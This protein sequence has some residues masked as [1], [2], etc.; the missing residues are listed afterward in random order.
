[1]IKC[2]N[3]DQSDKS[4]GAAL[5][6]LD[7]LYLLN[8]FDM[9]SKP[10]SSNDDIGGKSEADDDED[11]DNDIKM[12]GDDSND[13]LINIEN[14]INTMYGLINLTVS[15]LRGTVRGGILRLLGILSNRYPMKF[16]RI[17]LDKLAKAYTKYIGDS[18][19]NPSSIQ[20]G[21]IAGCLT[22]LQ[23][24]LNEHC[25]FIPLTPN[26]NKKGDNR[27]MLTVFKMIIIT[28]RT[29]ENE[30]RYLMVIA[31]LDLLS[32]HSF[33]FL[34]FIIKMM[35]GTAKL[36]RTEYEK[37]RN[38]DIL[39]LI[40]ELC[41]KHGNME[42]TLCGMSCVE[43]MLSSV[44][45][46]LL[47]NHNDKNKKI[48]NML[49]IIF[50]KL[51]S[52]SI[53]SGNR[54]NMLT[55]NNKQISLSIRA[56]GQLSATIN[57]YQNNQKLKQLLKTLVTVS[58]K[59]FVLADDTDSTQQQQGIGNNEGEHNSIIR[60]F[61]AF[62]TAFS[63]IIYHIDFVDD[64]VIDQLSLMIIMIYKGFP[65]TWN[66]LREKLYQSIIRLFVVL[67]LKGNIFNKLL[68]II[69]YK[70]LTYS[71]TTLEENIVG[72]KIADSSQITGI[73]IRHCYEEYYGFWKGLLMIGL[74]ID[75]N[76][77][78]MKWNK[79]LNLDMQQTQKY[80]YEMRSLLFSSIMQNLIEILQQFNLGFKV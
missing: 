48:F 80:L 25:D 31:S 62:L 35:E 49:L 3:T 43:S 63:S 69:I 33:L 20:P 16:T 78:S 70:G 14:V 47:E 58:K 2:V 51:L 32:R 38:G 42:V 15:K 6:C 75:D 1:M 68:E 52:K 60:Q 56:F 12:N 7:K 79:G 34:P 77:D 64:H 46:K 28:T 61:P 29:I 36:K 45:Q 24:F 27:N 5:K 59:C 17:H 4:R 23:Y 76:D 55:V 54:N 9:H 65:S 11:E 21:L 22:G 74:N 44:T 72:T 19:K 13:H 57:E 41:V 18:L 73:R 53:Q 39:Q 50:S 8:S 26:K 37:N 40:L 30:S 71:I 66:K 10:K 67:Y